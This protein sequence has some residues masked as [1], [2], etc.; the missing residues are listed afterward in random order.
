MVA[1][2]VAAHARMDLSTSYADG[3]GEVTPPRDRDADLSNLST[4][5]ENS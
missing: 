1:D 4:S 3:M 5:S 2:S